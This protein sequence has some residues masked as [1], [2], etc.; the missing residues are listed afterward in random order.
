[1]S[2]PSA[3]SYGDPT[4]PDSG[5]GG[6]VPPGFGA[7]VALETAVGC[8]ANV[9]SGASRT[10][11]D[12]VGQLLLGA[13]VV[14]LPDSGVNVTCGLGILRWA[15]GGREPFRLVQPM[16]IAPT[17]AQPGETLRYVVR[18]TSTQAAPIEFPG[19]P[20]PVYDE[21]L[22]TASG[23]NLIAETYELNCARTTRLAPGDSVSYAMDVH[24]PSSA[25]PGHYE[26]HW[27]IT[28]GY[29]W[30]EAGTATAPIMVQ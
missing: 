30:S 29:S 26:L 19:G 22:A 11:R 5:Q 12:D 28:G 13:G 8:P 9:K 6:N 2:R 10:G 7:Q 16:V 1:V 21:Q 25:V 17:T 24:V 14:P 18:L 23:A 27:T 20:C 15:V 3:F 4:D